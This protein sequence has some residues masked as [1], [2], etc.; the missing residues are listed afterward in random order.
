MAILDYS[1]I[2]IPTTMASKNENQNEMPTHFPRKLKLMINWCQQQVEKDLLEKQPI[3]WIPSGEGFS[4]KDPQIL[5]ERVL[6]N[7]FKS[8]NYQS[9]IRKLYHWSFKKGQ[10]T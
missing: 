9:L 8:T 3:E 2:A 4:I 1:T 7:F 5:T 6:P 10:S